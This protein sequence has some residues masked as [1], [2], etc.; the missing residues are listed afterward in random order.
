MS[1]KINKLEIENV[2]RVKAVKMEPSENGLTIIG[3]NNC[4][5][6]TSVLDAIA[7][8]LGGD[9]FRPSHASREGS[10]IPP[11]LKI[12]M[13]NG[14]VAERKGKNSDLKVTDPSGQKAGQQ[15]LNSFISEL[16]LN[17][18]KFLESNSREKADTLLQIIGVGPSSWQNWNGRKK[19]CV[20]NGFML[21]EQQIRKKSLRKNRLIIRMHHVIWCHHLN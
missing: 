5:G 2:K 13:N 16:A 17:L 20:T 10:V 9:R 1:M 18:P 19:N 12:V 7:W 8:A 21:G 11:T 3:G 14:L 6:K 15:L 4:Q